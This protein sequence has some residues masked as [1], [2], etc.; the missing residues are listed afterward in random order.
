MIVGR[1][2][3]DHSGLD[4]AITRRVR[5]ERAGRRAGAMAAAEA[6]VGYM[7]EAV[8]KRTNRYANGWTDAANKAGLGPFVPLPLKP[9]TQQE[10]IVEHLAGQAEAIER[11]ID[12]IADRIQKWYHD[13]GRPLSPWARK[14]Q[15]EVQRLWQQY[16][17][18]L[19]ALDK[20]SKGAS[21]IVF[22]AP[23]IAFVGDGGFYV[24]RAAGK[25]SRGRLILTRIDTEPKGG[26][27]EVLEGDLVTWV[28]LVNLEPHGSI[29]ESRKRNI[30]D[31]ER[32]VGLTRI[33]D[34]RRAIDR[35]AV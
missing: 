34:V 35:A 8:P 30:R 33:R 3:V 32:F 13:R 22:G 21:A 19:A 10:R 14:K 17:K 18:T 6:W 15:R 11:E 26:R 5:G 4:R 31:A 16:R 12:G 23:R 9:D 7:R 28:R 20:V 24:R 1:V 29:V 25:R 2:T 27:G